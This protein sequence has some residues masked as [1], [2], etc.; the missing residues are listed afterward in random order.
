MSALS[1]HYFIDSRTALNSHFIHTSPFSW[2]HTNSHHFQVDKSYPMYSVAKVRRVLFK[3]RMD[4]KSSMEIDRASQCF[5][6]ANIWC[7]KTQLTL[8]LDLLTIHIDFSRQHN[9]KVNWPAIKHKRDLEFS[10]EVWLTKS[11]KLMYLA[12]CTAIWDP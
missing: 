11:F 7:K 6:Q 9:L 3:N 4:D 12:I 2:R 1:F 10:K 8:W 5:Q